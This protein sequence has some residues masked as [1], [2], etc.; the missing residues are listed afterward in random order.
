V[1]TPVALAVAFLGTQLFAQT[2][3]V[4]QTQTEARTGTIADFAV[5]GTVPPQL[6]RDLA[7]LPGIR[8]S[9]VRRSTVV[10]VESDLGDQ[11]LSSVPAQ[12]LTDPAATIDA[13]V[14]SGS[15]A[16][17]TANTVAL[18]SDVTGDFPLGS[19][20]TLWLGDGTVVRPKVI[21]RYDRGL[22]FGDVLLPH[23]VLAAHTTS[24]LDD[25]LLIRGGSLAMLTPV[26][27]RYAGA[28]LVT[29]PALLCGLSH[30]IQQQGAANL[31]LAVLV[32]GFTAIGVATT[33]AMAT[34]GRRKELA[35][36]R[37]VGATR[38]QVLR[39]PRFE[40]VIALGT[41]ITVG[42]AIAAITLLGFAM[43]EFGRP[44]P[45]VPLGQ[46]VA[47]L[48]TIALVGSLSI[49]LPARSAL[50]HPPAETIGVPE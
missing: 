25:N 49:A 1:V 18:S 20:V 40:A 37:L 32:G 45:T 38:R 16:G 43:S 2:T 42:A 11:K 44:L 34:A 15:L 14:T 5:T 33:L 12:G 27:D 3:V 7:T 41:G 35:L 26:V 28:L 30:E 9:A 36:L 19:P 24:P 31:V 50:R 29:G 46:C 4:N 22:A 23:D 6:G 13:G 39:M 8:V 17:L 47:I 48:L 10:L 21:A